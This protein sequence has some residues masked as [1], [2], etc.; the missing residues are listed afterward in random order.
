MKNLVVRSEKRFRG[1]VRLLEEG[2]KNNTRKYTE[3]KE[4]LM[5]AGLSD[6]YAEKIIDELRIRGIIRKMGRLGSKEPYEIDVIGLKE[7]LKILEIR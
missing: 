2:K 7:A 6:D 3:I 1:L 5:E 4:I